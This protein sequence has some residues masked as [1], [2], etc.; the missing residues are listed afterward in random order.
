MR[1]DIVCTSVEGS[2]NWS[3]VALD[4]SHR[5]IMV[6]CGF[7]GLNVARALRGVPVD[8]T[9]VD[10]RNFHLFQRLDRGR[11][12]SAGGP[13]LTV[14]ISTYSNRCCIGLQPGVC[15]Q[16][17]YQLRLGHSWTRTYA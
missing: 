15:L 6:G 13:S 10:C 12:G 2:H 11:A 5:V 14:G 1:C 9:V 16:Q 17:T 4:P 7:A 8:L 3:K